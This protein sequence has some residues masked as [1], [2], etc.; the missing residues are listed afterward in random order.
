MTNV[1]VRHK[2]RDWDTWKPIFDEHGATRKAAGSK[3]CRLFRSAGD[4][5]EVIL[6]FDWDSL[7]NAKRFVES[8]DLRE[9]MERAGVVDIPDVYFLEEKARPE[10]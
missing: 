1:I 3:G 4:P 2:I 8:Q 10:C 5:N 9:V 7:E 6:L